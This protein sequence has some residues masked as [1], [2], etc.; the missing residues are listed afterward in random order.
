MF[1]EEWKETF[2]LPSEFR[3]KTTVDGAEIRDASIR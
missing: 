1:F 3:A 2:V